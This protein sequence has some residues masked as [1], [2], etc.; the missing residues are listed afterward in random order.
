MV[1][2]EYLAEPNPTGEAQPEVTLVDA[3]EEAGATVPLREAPAFLSL[4]A[5]VAEVVVYTVVRHPVTEAVVVW[6][7]V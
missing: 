2:R 5:A 1:Q 7:A 6:P 3:V 4:R